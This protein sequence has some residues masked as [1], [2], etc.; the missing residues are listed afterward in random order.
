MVGVSNMKKH[1]H[2]K[3][4]FPFKVHLRG[5]RHR[6]A[7]AR[8][9]SVRYTSLH[10]FRSFTLPICLPAASTLPSRRSGG[11][12]GAV[13]KRP[14]PVGVS[15]APPCRQ[16]PRSWCGKSAGLAPRLPVLRKG[17]LLY[18]SQLSIPEPEETRC[19]H[20]LGGLAGKW[21]LRCLGSS[22]FEGLVAVGQQRSNTFAHF[23]A[24][25]KIIRCFWFQVRQFSVK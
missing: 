2:T 11:S 7:E 25:S 14:P 4:L 19:R 1:M 13:M 8:I 5:L 10:I 23:A 21:R 24:Q 22:R 3:A 15:L 18:M 6:I 20:I 16:I 17:N 9:V 12:I